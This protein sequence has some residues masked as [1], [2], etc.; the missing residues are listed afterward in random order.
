MDRIPIF[1]RKMSDETR[2]L[3]GYML[4]LKAEIHVWCVV[5]KRGMYR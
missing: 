5:Y 2:F 3:K 1:R 4:G